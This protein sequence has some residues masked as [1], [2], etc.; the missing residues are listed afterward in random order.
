VLIKAAIIMALT[1]FMRTIYA[2]F[3]I[4]QALRLGWHKL[5]ALSILS[6]ILSLILVGLGV[7]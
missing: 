3:R 7:L 1:V 2:R 4:D 5:F 6:V